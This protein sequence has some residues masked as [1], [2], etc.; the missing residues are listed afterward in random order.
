ML[1]SVVLVF[2]WS[3]SVVEPVSVLVV[4][5]PI[6]ILILEGIRNNILESQAHPY[7]WSVSSNPPQFAA[8]NYRQPTAQ[9][10]G[11]ANVNVMVSMAN[12]PSYA[13]DPASDNS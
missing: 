12:I 8:N 9:N 11:C 7:S 13:S 3:P 6:S 2:V 4:V 5:I 1:V 10:I